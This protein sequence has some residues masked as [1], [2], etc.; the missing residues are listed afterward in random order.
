MRVRRVQFI[1]TDDNRHLVRFSVEESVDEKIFLATYDQDMNQ[2]HLESSDTLFWIGDVFDL[3][4]QQVNLR[5][6][7]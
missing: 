4:E 2:V 7:D 6:F 3:L 1:E 5:E